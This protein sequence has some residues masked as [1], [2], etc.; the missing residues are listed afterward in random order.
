MSEKM[1][2]DQAIDKLEADLKEIEGLT[3]SAS[4]SAESAK[5]MIACIGLDC[6]DK[7]MGL[8]ELGKVSDAERR[9]GWTIIH[10]MREA[11]QLCETAESDAFW[12]GNLIT[13]M[14]AHIA[15]NVRPVLRLIRSLHDQLAEAN[16]RTV[17]HLTSDPDV[18]RKVWGMTEGKCIY[19]ASPLY[20][21]GETD[22]VL[23]PDVPQK[24]FH[25]DHIVPKDAGGPD[26]IC[27]YVPACQTCN[28]SKS[29][30]PF[31]EF[32]TKREV[33]LRVVGGQE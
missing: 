18:R 4:G 33:K 15:N 5:A 8:V 32:V 17:V 26:H 30:K 16:A 12:M 24:P 22:L 14:Q 21:P 7:F 27:N 13:N 20:A 31:A 25:V 2:I 19:C 23:A 10:R 9:D 28:I 29:N 6:A 3:F 11:R 1:S